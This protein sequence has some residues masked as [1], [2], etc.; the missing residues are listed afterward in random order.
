MQVFDGD[1]LTTDVEVTGHPEIYLNVSTSTGKGHLFVYLE[2]V[3]PDVT[4]RYIT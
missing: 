2:E 4:S 3:L 1:V